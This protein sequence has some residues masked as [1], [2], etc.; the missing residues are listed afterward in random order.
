MNTLRTRRA[1]LLSVAATLALTGATLNAQAQVVISQIYGGGGSASA[2][3]F[4]PYAN[5]F[6]ELYNNG[7]S[8]V[9]LSTYSIQYASA[10]GTAT[11]FTGVLT[12]SIPANSY[13]FIKGGNSGGNQGSPIPVGFEDVSFSTL[14]ISNSN[15]KVFL[16]NKTTATVFPAGNVNGT[17]NITDFVGYGTATSYENTAAPGLTKTSSLVRNFS[18]STYT[19]TNSNLADF[20]VNNSGKIVI[21]NSR[22]Q[23]ASAPSPSA[24]LPFAMGVPMLALRLRK[25]RK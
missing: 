18:G 3:P 11:S 1:G 4:A 24:L 6:V 5:D 10:A 20:T 22:G 16:S 14:N 9:D 23:I 19:D 21:H 12:G 25:R 15:A 17:V 2:A 13:Y 7:T 8:P